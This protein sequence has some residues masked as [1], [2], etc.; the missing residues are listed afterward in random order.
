MKKYI[1]AFSFFPF[2]I[3]CKQKAH[4]PE[5]ILVDHQVLNEALISFFPGS[6]H[7][8]GKH[9][10]WVNPFASNLFAHIHSAQNGNEIARIGEIGVGPEEFLSPTIGYVSNDNIFVWDLNSDKEAL[11]P[12]VPTIKGESKINLLPKLNKGEITGLTF[13]N[14]SVRVAIHPTD[15]TLFRMITPSDQYNFGTP[16]IDM[17][18]NNYFDTYQGLISYNHNRQLLVFSFFNIPY[19]AIYKLHNTTFKLIKEINQIHEMKIAQKE[20]IVDRT[21][22]WVRELTL[23]KDY[24]VC[25]QRDYEI[26]N[27]DE[28]K[29]GRDFSKLPKTLFLYDYNGNHTKTLQTTNP[30]IRIASTI[31]SNTIYAI[32]IDDEYQL[33]SI[34]F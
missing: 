14:D 27:M 10:I 30:I 12:I 16:P 24:I 33:V 15:S 1:V 18:I 34:D 6:L 32:I 5:T 26:D 4:Q 7:T 25:V 23:T 28:S 17:K 31:N 3:C 20:L 9:L 8:D 21:K 22:N 29:V 13:I 19:T 2:L 11:I